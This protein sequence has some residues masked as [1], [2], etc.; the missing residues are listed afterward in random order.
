LRLDLAPQR[1]PAVL[2][3]FLRHIPK[4]F[5]SS[6][7]AGA[8]SGLRRSLR[9]RDGPV[10]CGPFLGEP[11][12]E[13]LYWIPFLRTFAYP[14][15]S[16]GCD[17]T[18]VSRGGV[19]RLYADLLA[20]GAT[21]LDVLDVFAHEDFIDL[22]RERLL[23]PR[24]KNQKQAGPFETKILDEA[25]YS[26]ARPLLPA[27]MFELLARY[28]PSSICDW[29]NWPDAPEGDREELTLIKLWFGGQM[30][31]LDANIQRL[32]GWIERFA[33]EGPVAA[34]VN[35]HSLEVNP[36]VDQPFTDIVERLRLPTMT[37][38]SHRTNLG[39]QIEMLSRCTRFVATYGGLAYLSVYTR[40]PLVSFYTDPKIVFSQ[41]YL[42]FAT[43]VANQNVKT[44]AGELSV[45]LIDLAVTA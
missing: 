11:G 45:S 14:L 22:E 28:P 17:V 4:R 37:T 39:D 18:I 19:E 29:R 25:G 15:L 26:G 38:S 20:R 6:T 9:R 44:K 5:G 31:A 8:V 41:H 35:D 10:I 16:D 42:N 3:T 30:P 2:R 43:A 12:F 1:A 40:T 27:H 23:D 33:G 36:G 21:Y 13:T 32:E 24:A 7:A 34:I